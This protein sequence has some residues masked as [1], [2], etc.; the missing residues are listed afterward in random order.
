ML[1]L[2][3]T[4]FLLASDYAAAEV[5]KSGIAI[6]GVMIMQPIEKLVHVVLVVGLSLI[7]FDHGVLARATRHQ[8][9]PSALLAESA[10]V[11]SPER[12]RGRKVSDSSV[13]EA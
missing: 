9:C 8:S 1:K 4:S 11:L 2:F 6:G 10:G 3:S 7:F 12:P 5:F 13:S